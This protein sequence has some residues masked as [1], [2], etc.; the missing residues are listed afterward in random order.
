MRVRREG[1]GGAR[2]RTPAEMKRKSGGRR[3]IHPVTLTTP[4]AFERLTPRPKRFG[5]FLSLAGADG[6]AE[7]I[8]R[9]N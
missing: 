6:R 3:E 9:A 5:R 1:F 2:S 7:A 8:I 4:G